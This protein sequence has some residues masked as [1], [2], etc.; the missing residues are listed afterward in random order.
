MS[1]HDPGLIYHN[2]GSISMLNHN[3][4][5]CKLLWLIKMTYNDLW[6][7]TRSTMNSSATITYDKL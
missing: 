5:Y 1:S 7:Y 2:E 4:H 6:W 3:M